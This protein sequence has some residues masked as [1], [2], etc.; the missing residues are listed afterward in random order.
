MM[1]GSINTFKNLINKL[2]TF[3]KISGLKLN[4]NKTIILRSGS[5]KN[6][7]ETFNTGNK[8]TWTSENANTLGITFP[9]NKQM[10]NEY[11]IIPKVK[12]FCNC[13]NKWKK[14]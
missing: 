8:F 14:T 4:S 13:L 7:N 5:L 3:G 12:E 10:Y 11:N 2:D 6:S 1:D 9:N